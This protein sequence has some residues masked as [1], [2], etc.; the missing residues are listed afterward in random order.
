MSIRYSYVAV[1]VVAS[2][3]GAVSSNPIRASICQFVILVCAAFLA[4]LVK[5]MQMK[6]P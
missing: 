5:P 4:P 6:L 3:L 2:K 1:M